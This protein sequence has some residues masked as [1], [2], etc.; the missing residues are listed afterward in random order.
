MDKAHAGIK[1]NELADRGT[2]DALKKSDITMIHLCIQDFFVNIFMIHKKYWREYWIRNTHLTG[3]G[4][5]LRS[6]RKDEFGPAEIQFYRKT[7]VILTRL[8]T[9]HVRSMLICK[10][11]KSSMA[12]SLP[13]ENLL[14]Q[15]VGS[16]INYLQ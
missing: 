7:E 1:G 2:K 8:R 16:I 10:K 13:V 9:G 14:P 12:N 11:V 4:Q 6:V 3:E 5:F 15:N